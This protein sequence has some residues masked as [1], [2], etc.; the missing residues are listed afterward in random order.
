MGTA[1]SSLTPDERRICAMMGL[2][3]QQFL[4]Q[5]AAMGGSRS[6]GGYVR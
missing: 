4:A 3:E 5:K 2:T 6:D 1:M